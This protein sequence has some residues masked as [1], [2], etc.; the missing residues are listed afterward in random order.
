MME[1]EIIQ[2]RKSESNCRVTSSG[3]TIGK[4]I[5][6]EKSFDADGM[7]GAFDVDLTSSCH[8]VDMT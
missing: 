1:L 5:T 2:S 7:F 6:G 8:L 3:Q 4:R